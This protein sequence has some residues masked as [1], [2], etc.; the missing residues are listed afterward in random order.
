M[1]HLFG[2]IYASPVAGMVVF[3]SGLSLAL[4]G[5][6][7]HM[8]PVRSGLNSF[9]V[10]LCILLILC[11][12]WFGITT[13]KAGDFVAGFL[14]PFTAALGLAVPVVVFWLHLRLANKKMK[15]T[16]VISK[17]LRPFVFTTGILLIFISLPSLFKYLAWFM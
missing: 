2:L 13:G 7:G 15:A 14:A 11:F 17:W 1:P 10:F 9:L 4:C 8:R 3:L 5:Y 16:R 6:L 12:L